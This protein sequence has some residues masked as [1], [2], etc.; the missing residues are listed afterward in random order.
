MCLCFHG[1]RINYNYMNNCLGERFCCRVAIT[2][3]W[4]IYLRNYL[5]NNFVDH[6]TDSPWISMHVHYHCPQQHYIHIKS[7]EKVF[8]L[9]GYNYNYIK[10][11]REIF[12][13]HVP[14]FPTLQKPHLRLHTNNCLKIVLVTTVARIQ[15]WILSQLFF[16]IVSWSMVLIYI[17]IYMCVCVFL[18][19]PFV[20]KNPFRKSR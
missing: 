3:T 10:N 2:I 9:Q 17:Y 11:S 16:V 12:F 20:A 19:R 15:S 8:L 18:P 7:F 13:L 6:G 5:R 1:K 4:I 14:M